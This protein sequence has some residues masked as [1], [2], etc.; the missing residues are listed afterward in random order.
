MSNAKVLAITKRII[1]EYTGRVATV[2]SELEGDLE[3][4]MSE[5]GDI[6]MLIEDEIDTS[7]DNIDIDSLKTVGDL[8]RAIISQL[9]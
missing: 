5:L 4:S 6:I 8:W 3:T 7:L 2:D 1:K 9:Q